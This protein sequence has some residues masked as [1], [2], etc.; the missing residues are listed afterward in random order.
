M[1]PFTPL[2]PIQ[3]G[4][5]LTNP[6][7]AELRA[8]NRDERK[9]IDPTHVEQPAKLGGFR[10]TEAWAIEIAKNALYVIIFI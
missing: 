6:F 10:K 1:D 3:L 5:V 4:D 8:L 2:P 9:L 7:G